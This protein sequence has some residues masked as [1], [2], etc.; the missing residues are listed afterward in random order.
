[1]R[2]A[3]RGLMAVLLVAPLGLL[4]GCQALAA[5]FLMWGPEPTKDVPAEYPY[6]AGKKVCVLV[7]A[8]I[9]TLLQYPNVPLE[10]SEYIRVALEPNV[11]GIRFVSNR[12]VANMQRRDASWDRRRPALIGKDFEADRVVEVALSEYTTREPDSP[13]L[14]RGRITAM[15]KVHDTAL[16]DAGPSYKTELSTAYPPESIGEYGTEERTIRRLT[17]EAFAADVAAKFYDRKVKIR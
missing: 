13:Q 2:R 1:M 10:L 12:E 8:D 14:Y 16:P 15:I 9:E 4:V 5:P 6:L 11:K 7:W 3:W 17:M